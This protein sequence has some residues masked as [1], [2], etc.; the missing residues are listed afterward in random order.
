[1]KTIASLFLSLLLASLA[2]RQA[3]PGQAGAATNSQPATAPVQ[4]SSDSPKPAPEME[5]LIEMWAGHWTT[6][7]QFEPSA[8]MPQGKQ[9]KG[10]ESMR[11]GPGGLSLIG[12]YES[13]G[14]FFG[15]MVVTWIPKEKVYK[16]YWHDLSQ[17]GVS[18]ST[19]RWEGDKLVFTSVDESTGNKLEVRD[20]YSDI[21]ATSF[22]DT[23]EAGPPGGPMKKILTIKYTKQAIT[24]L[25][26]FGH[27]R[28]ARAHGCEVSKKF[29]LKKAQQLSGVL[30]DPMEAPLSGFQLDLIQNG[31]P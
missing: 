27:A 6:V 10:A 24:A 22:T 4:A 21:T 29:E 18:I 11:P 30:E 26:G 28:S 31:K 3:N 9:D 5:K 12:D 17:P 8:E 16:S 13:H 7:E 20:T 25:A 23:L 2:A 19:G 1:M 14:A 15:H